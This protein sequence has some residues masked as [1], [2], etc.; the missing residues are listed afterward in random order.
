MVSKLAMEE[1]NSGN[2]NSSAV[3][4]TNPNCSQN[5]QQ[6]DEMNSSVISNDPTHPNSPYYIGSNDGSSLLLVTH[7]L[8]SNNYN[9]WALSMR[10]AL[11]I[12]S[13]L[14]FID[15]TLCE[16]RD[17]NDS[18]MEHCLRC[19]DIIITWMQNAM[20]ID[21]KSSTIYAETAHLF[22]LDLE[23]RFS[24]QNAPCIFEVKKDITTLI[25]NQDS[26]SVYFSKLKILLDEL[27]N[28][29]SIPN[30]SCDD[31]KTVIPTKRLGYEVPNGA[32]RVLQG[33]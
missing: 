1:S 17:P 32:K 13:K 23:Q 8:D 19:N 15:G 24:Q 10:R 6:I 5:L 31:L 2:T 33:N 20:V 30:C 11:R 18:L 9:S 21:I 22:W 12:K 25:Q 29:K 7:V 4:N 26:M 14:G 16:P 3:P 28:Y 27:L